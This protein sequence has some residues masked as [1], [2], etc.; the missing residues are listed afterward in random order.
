MY[1]DAKLSLIFLLN[2]HYWYY[3]LG[4]TELLDPLI[5]IRLQLVKFII[6][7]NYINYEVKL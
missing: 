6:L 7:I 4:L 5:I 3:I 1:P 2:I